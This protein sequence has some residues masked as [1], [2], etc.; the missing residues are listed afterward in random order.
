MIQ[1]KRHRK[2]DYSGIRNQLSE[3]QSN[4]VFMMICS[5]LVLVAMGL[6]YITLSSLLV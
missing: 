3:E 5:V 6:I 2:E 4:V 1:I